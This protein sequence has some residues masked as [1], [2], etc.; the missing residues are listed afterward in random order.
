MSPGSAVTDAATVSGG[1]GQPTPTGTVAFFLCQPNEVAV[2]QGCVSGGTQI[3]SVKTLSNGQATSDAA[4]GAST[5]ALGKLCWRAE[6]S[7]D[8][9]YLPSSH[10]DNTNEC[11][12]PARQPSTTA[13]QAST[14][15]TSVTPGTSVSDTATVSGGAG[16]PTPTGTV[17]FFLCQPNEVTAGQGCVSGGTLIGAAK[18]LSNGQATSDATT[19]TNAVG[20]YCWRAVYSGDGFYSPSSHTNAASE[21]FTTTVLP[22]TTATQSNPT[23]ANVTPGTSVTDAATVTGSAGQ[24]TPTGTVAF[25]LCQPNEVTA[26]QGCVSGGTQIGSAKTLSNGQVTSD[27]TTNTTA[28]GTY[29]WRAE[30][31]GDNVYSGS[32]HTNATTECFSTLLYRITV[33]V[34]TA[35]TT[36]RFHSSDVTFG[37][38]VPSASTGTASE[39]CAA[40]ANFNNLDAGVTP[41]QIIIDPNSPNTP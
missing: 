4:S 14:N 33:I 38:T 37:A 40:A 1:A 23:G 24:P 11:F 30:Y 18:A 16:Q 12:R 15:S 41:I 13:T 2:G 39:L 36:P 8:A 31:S 27:A 25:F 7:G 28:V 26:G 5:S 3:G 35:E 21:C 9:F 19:N 32:S 10:T 34:C 20:Q 22:S 29:C 17:A 6:Y